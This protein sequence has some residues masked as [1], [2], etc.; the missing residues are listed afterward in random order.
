MITASDRPWLRF[1]GDVPDSLEYPEITLYEALAASA[2]RTP[3]AT[4]Y[5]FLGVT[6]TYAELIASVDCCANAL[7]A[8]GLGPGDRITISMPTSPQG[9]IPFYAAAK[10]GAVAS[11][12]H[13]LSAP[14]EIAGYLN[15]SGS[16]IAVTL[17]AF[18]GSFAGIEETTPLETLILARITDDLPL[19]KRIGFWA[20]RGRKIARVPPDPRVRWWSELMAEEHPAVPAAAI[21]THEPAAILYSGGTTGTPKGIVLSHH[22]FVSEGMQVGA[23]IGMGPHDTILAALPIFH[24]FGLA[25]LINAGFLSGAQLV[26]V[27]VFSPETTAEL[28][29]TKRPTLIAGVPTLYEA[30]IR[31]PALQTADLS[32]LRGA[33]SGA[34]SL[35]E[36]VRL[37][38]EALVAERGG[39]VR[40][41]E[42]YGLTEAVTGIMGMPLN[43]SRPGSIGVPLPDTLVAIC[44]LDELEELPVGE[45]GEICVSGPAVML[46]YLDDPDATA[47][48]LKVHP[49]GRDLAPHRR[50][51]PDGRGRV[52]L[53]HVAPQADDQVVRV[54]RLPLSGRDGAARAPRRGRGLCGRRARP[55]SGR[56][57]RR[58]RRPR[59][60]RPRP[61]TR[62]RPS[63]SSTAARISSSGRARARS[64]SAPSCRRPASGRSTSRR[65]AAR[66]PSGDGPRSRNDRARREP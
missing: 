24:G 40:L 7:A 9:V 12:I 10:L 35:P 64:S 1:Y 25:A 17:D 37:G 23:W 20:T 26:L 2:R 41:L 57:G 32:S 50:H 38:F 45:E 11:M 42:G 5:D 6:A 51:R 47:A 33:F 66:S 8:L 21:G 4:A 31:H 56:A 15:R 18:Y 54:Q 58:G 61:A 55:G 16:R 30:L 39:H 49:D 36:P 3:E 44:A 34:D 29:Q 22:N 19:L 13:P 27:P 43:E 59:R 62:W 53:L 63:S 48:T 14:A 52:L 46:G 65:W 28:L 60:P